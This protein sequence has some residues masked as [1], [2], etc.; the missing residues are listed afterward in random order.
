MGRI[1]VGILTVLYA[2]AVLVLPIAT[3]CRSLLRHQQP[4]VACVVSV[5]LSLLG[6]V[7]GFLAMFLLA[8]FLVPRGRE[9]IDMQGTFV[10]FLLGAL[11][12]LPLGTW[13][14]AWSVVWFVIGKP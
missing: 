8:A 1:V 9:L 11:L 3:A 14:G 7:A 6:G 2:L 13:V 4:G 12:G 5:V 10:S